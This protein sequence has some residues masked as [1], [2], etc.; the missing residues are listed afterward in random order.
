MRSG[1]HFLDWQNRPIL[2]KT[3]PGLEPLPLP[4][5]LP[6]SGM[7]AL[8]A[9][10]AGYGWPAGT[11]APGLP[12]LAHLLYHSGGIT[13]KLVHREGAAFFRAAACAGALYPIELYLVCSTLPGLEAGVYHFSPADFALRLLRAGDWL[14]ALAAAAG[15]RPDLAQAPA[16]LALT[17]ITWRS[18]WKY[19]A[20]AYRYHYW[21]AGTILANA[22]AAARGLGFPATVVLGFVDAL[23]D[24]LLGIDGRVEKSICLMP[25]GHGRPS[26]ITGAVDIPELTVS[27]RP[28]AIKEVVYTALEEFHQASCLASSEAVQVWQAEAAAAKPAPPPESAPRVTLAPDL[29]FRESGASLESAILHRGSSRRFEMSSISFLDLSNLLALAGQS[30]PAG[31]RKGT[32]GNLNEVYLNA[33]A[34]ADLEPGAYY[35]Q[36]AAGELLSLR[37]GQLRG[38]SAFLCLEQ[39]LGGEASFTVFF[40][41]DLK[42]IWE[43]Y[44][45]RGYRAAQLEAGIM[46]GRLYLAA[47]A[48]GLGAT[49]LTFYDDLVVDFF[50]PG[51]QGMHAI[52][53]TACGRPAAPHSPRGRIVRLG[54]GQADPLAA[55]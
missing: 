3:Y 47:Y 42:R 38:D 26:Q 22:L 11:R 30:I 36:Q 21:D 48:L 14:P 15:N 45:N 1:G 5:E 2:Y 23:V 33:H 40:L 53:V 54:P 27:S 52:F 6:T 25:F 9:L 10:S 29:D 16:V 34:V 46:G 12:D 41:A 44:G 32:G 13:K 51:S 7:A 55:A 31:W 49:G 50:A 35:Y 4:T 18:T 28:H 43:Q 39:S 19:Q 17:A 37:P 24:R 20:R 8:Q